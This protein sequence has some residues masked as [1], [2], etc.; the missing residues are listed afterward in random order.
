MAE[1]KSII[2]PIPGVFYRRPSPEEDVYVKEG[3]HVKA[4][5]VIGLVEVMKNFHEIKADTDG[6]LVR[7]TVENEE[8]VD[9]GGEI[10]IIEI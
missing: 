2:S 6:T 10:A 9:A 7:F 8:V 1:T 5:D 4:G 3:E